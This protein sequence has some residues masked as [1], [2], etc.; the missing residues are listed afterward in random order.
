LAAGAPTTTAQLAT[1]FPGVPAA[2]ISGQLSSLLTQLGVMAGAGGTQCHNTC[3]GA[4]ARPGYMGGQGAT[5]VMTLCP[6]FLHDFTLDDRVEMLMHEGMHASPGS[7]VVDQAYRSQ[8]VIGS[9]TGP[10]AETNTDSY[11]NLILRLQPGVSGP[12]P[13]GPPTDPQVGMTAAEG[14]AAERALGFIEKWVEVA[15]WDTSQL[16]EAIK[17]NIGRAGG[18]NPAD[19]YHAETQHAIG[20]LLTLTDPGNVPPFLI[21]PV[22][23]DQVKVAGIHDRYDRM[24]RAVASTPITMTKGAADAWAASLGASLS[25]CPTSLPLARWTRCC[26]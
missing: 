6:A 17:G 1:F 10:Q 24:N 8:R 26:D 3:D 5:A 13:G 9:L 15:E 2:T 7:P 25:S 23:A 19:Q 11:I 18:W 14:A 4:C 21:T 12:I 16:Y 22:R 20:W